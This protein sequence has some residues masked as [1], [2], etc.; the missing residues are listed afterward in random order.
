MNKTRFSRK[1]PIAGQAEYQKR[2]QT[3]P[4]G[5]T[6]DSGRNQPSNQQKNELRTAEC[7]ANKPTQIK[8]FFGIGHR[9]KK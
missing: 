9:N 2:F 7:Q 5:Y 3:Q 4:A 8:A 6:I 1:W